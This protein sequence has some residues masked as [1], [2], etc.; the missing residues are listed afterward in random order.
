[1]KSFFLNILSSIFLF[2]G[3]CLCVMCRRRHVRKKRALVK[4]NHGHYT[5]LFDETITLS[6][7][8]ELYNQ[9]DLSKVN[10]LSTAGHYDLYFYS[11]RSGLNPHSLTSPTFTNISSIECSYI[12]TNF[13]HL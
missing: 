7:I 1:M 4:S 12:F 13:K 6:Y 2:L 11:C 9:L 5:G 10:L 8:T 3:A